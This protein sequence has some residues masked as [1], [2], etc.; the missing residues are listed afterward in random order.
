MAGWKQ[1]NVRLAR[2]GREHEGAAPQPKTEEER[3]KIGIRLSRSRY[4]RQRA[5]GH[6]AEA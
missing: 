6:R 3:R 2:G 1:N 4:E 5:A